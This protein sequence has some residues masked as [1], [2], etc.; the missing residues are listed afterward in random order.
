MLFSV[1][2]ALALLFLLIVRRPRATPTRCRCG[3]TALII[4][5]T[6]SRG[7]CYRCYLKT[8]LNTEH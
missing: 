4:D 6:R 3:A 1:L 8:T 5:N 7:M 2:I